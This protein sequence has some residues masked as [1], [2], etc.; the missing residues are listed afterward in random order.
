MKRYSFAE[1]SKESI[2]PYVQSPNKKAKNAYITVLKVYKFNPCALVAVFVK[3]GDDEKAGF[4][5]DLAVMIKE[6]HEETK[7]LKLIPV[8]GDRRVLGVDE[9]KVLKSNGYNWRVFFR[10]LS[11]G[12]MVDVDKVANKFGDDLAKFFNKEISQKWKY[13][14]PC[15]F[16]GI[17]NG[18]AFADPVRSLSTFVMPKSVVAYCRFCFSG[19]IESGAFFEDSE[20][21][22][23]L[24][25][26][27]EDPK[28]LF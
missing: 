8:I 7:K 16:Y 18:G 26:G 13:P 19:G 23:E 25:P 27:V 14:E 3:N 17:E 11:D 1:N 4:S 21:M 15:E 5:N 10:I 6:G 28:E 9:V 2:I 22:D 24:F 12:E 20:L